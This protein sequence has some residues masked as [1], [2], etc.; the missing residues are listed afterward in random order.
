MN[1]EKDPF[2]R[3]SGEKDFLRQQPGIA[4]ILYDKRK[5]CIS[6]LERIRRNIILFYNNWECLMYKIYP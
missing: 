4:I 5:M 6:L 2:S 1:S 3:D